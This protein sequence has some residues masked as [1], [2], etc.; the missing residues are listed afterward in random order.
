MDDKKKFVI[1][2]IDEALEERQNSDRRKNQGLDHDGE[3]R[4]KFDRR[5]SGKVQESS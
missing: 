5:E 4:R 2:Q 3:D 1:E